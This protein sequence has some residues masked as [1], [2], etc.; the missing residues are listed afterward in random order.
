MANKAIIEVS[1]YEDY[2]ARGLDVARKFDRG[3]ELPEADYHLG[4]TDAAQLFS[5]LTP[6]R[7]QLLDTLKGL[8]PGSV[9]ALAKK[10]GRNYSNVHRDIELLTEYGLVEKDDKSQVSVP[11]D[12][13]EIHL[14]L[15]REAA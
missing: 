4:F 11:W 8:G 15:K 13:V 2:R 14:G 10:L 9:Y 12:S 7:L 6:K 1:T 5:V 3:A